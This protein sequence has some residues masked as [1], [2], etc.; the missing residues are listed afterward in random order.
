MPPLSNGAYRASDYQKAMLVCVGSALFFNEAFTNHH[1]PLLVMG[2]T[3][4]M[5]FLLV[6]ALFG[7]LQRA[8]TSFQ[9]NLSTADLGIGQNGQVLTVSVLIR[10]WSLLYHCCCFKYQSRLSNTRTRSF[11]CPISE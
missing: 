3:Q 10:V 2:W 9:R 1:H 6:P 11:P 5:W 8:Q 7:L 4:C